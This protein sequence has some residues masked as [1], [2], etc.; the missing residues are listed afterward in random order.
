YAKAAAAYEQ[1]LRL[2]AGGKQL[3]DDVLVA[4]MYNSLGHCYCKQGAYEKAVK[5]GKEAIGHN[6]NFAEAY[7]NRGYA[8]Y[9]WGKLPEAIADL[10][11]AIALDSKPVY[12]HYVLGMALLAKDDRGGAGAQFALCAQKDNVPA[13]YSMEMGIICLN[14]GKYDSAYSYCRK[15]FESD[16][17]NGYAAYYTAVAL[18]VQGKAEES[19]PW[20]EQAFRR[21]IPGHSELKKERLLANIRRNGKFRELLNKYY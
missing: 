20:F 2:S 4:E 6:R 17:T 8:Y 19:M 15:A 3:A 12:W 13:S 7:C 5:N 14:M 9:K 11:K 16:S 10:Q 1:A 21:K 18:S